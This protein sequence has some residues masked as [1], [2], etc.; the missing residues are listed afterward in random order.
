MI[1]SRSALSE[2]TAPSGAVAFAVAAARS[3]LS[4]AT[5][6]I[7]FAFAGTAI[8]DGHGQLAD[9]P[10]SGRPAD[11][12]LY[13]ISP[14]D[15]AT[16]RSPVVVRFGLAGMGVAPA[17]V[18]KAGTGHHHLVIDAE[19]PPVDLPIPKSDHYRHFGAGQTEVALDLA[20]GPHTLQL[21]LADHLHIPHDPPA[22]SERIT[23]T[24]EE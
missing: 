19:L 18:E 10:R 5:V 15:G 20:S 4:V 11:A 17:G 21:V 3:V 9:L 22:I 8:A 16:A 1:Q 13:L 6:T 23:I 2:S 14:E 7:S 12:R 24:V